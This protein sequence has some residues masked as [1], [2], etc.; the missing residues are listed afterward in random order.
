MH[1]AVQD[2]AGMRPADSGSISTVSISVKEAAVLAERTRAIATKHE[3]YIGHSH[4]LNVGLGW[5]LGSTRRIRYFMQL[6]WARKSKPRML[7]QDE[8]GQNVHGTDLKN[9]S[10]LACFHKTPIY[11]PTTTYSLSVS[12]TA[13]PGPPS[14]FPSLTS[15]L[16]LALTT[17]VGVV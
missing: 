5:L 9:F 6:L 13:P 16:P 11:P 7:Y 1:R 12:S 10:S 17:P 4:R 3:Y 2:M 15:T 8:N 14:C